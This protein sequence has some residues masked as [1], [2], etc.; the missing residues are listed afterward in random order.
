[1]LGHGVIEHREPKRLRDCE[2]RTMH[3]PQHVS[4]REGGGWGV[5]DARLSVKQVS[6]TGVL[7]ASLPNILFYDLMLPCCYVVVVFVAIYAVFLWRLCDSMSWRQPA[8]GAVISGGV[9]TSSPLRPFIV[10]SI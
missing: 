1:M 8:A 6:I 2:A 9:A 10:P 5:K 4:L 3:N 7:F